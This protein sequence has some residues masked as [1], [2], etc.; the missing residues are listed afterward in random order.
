VF[1]IVFL[2]RTQLK[3]NRVAKPVDKGMNLGVQPAARQSY[4]FLFAPFFPPFA[5]W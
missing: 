4:G 2:P 1:G 3:R 5:L